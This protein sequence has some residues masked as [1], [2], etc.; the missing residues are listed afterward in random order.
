MERMIERIF[1]QA[2]IIIPIVAAIS[3]FFSEWRFPL[4][5][6]IGGI[7]FLVSLRS[8]AWAVK[9]YLGKAMGQQII[10]G[11]STIK[12]LLIFLVLATLATLKLINIIGLVLGFITSLIITVKEGF[13]TARREI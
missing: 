2:L 8:L 1:K 4:S 12:I 11:I 9:K 7:V 13:I 3:F 6:L 10:I 5:V